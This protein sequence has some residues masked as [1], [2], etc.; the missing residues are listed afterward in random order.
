MFGIDDAIAIPA[1]SS[2]VGS[3]FGFGGQ[4]RTNDLN[5]QMAQSQMDFQERM[6][7]TSYQ[8]AVQ[9]L[10]AAGLNPMLALMHG[11]ASSPGGAMPQIGNSIGAGLASGREAAQSAGE[12]MERAQ[13]MK[14]KDPLSQIAALVS[15]GLDVIKSAIP[16]GGKAVSEA[17]Q[18]VTDLI[19]EVS[20]SSAGENAKA[21]G[22]KVPAIGAAQDVVRDL[23]MKLD[24]VVS[25][26]G[27]MLSKATSSAADA[28]R[29]GQRAESN[30]VPSNKIRAGRF[31]GNPEV[32]R[33]D[34]DAI[35]DPVERRQ[36][37]MSYNLWLHNNRR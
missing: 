2:A 18:K 11:G 17:A 3:L 27:K 12:T 28:V 10:K 8:R 15:Q 25:A 1:I 31:T 33:K 6:S 30:F 13:R 23:G 14:I 16:A 24:D 26:P 19:D 35:K 9:D 34:I 36:A 21:L 37:R 22:K 4:E 32:D 5:R 29:N 20:S 7:G